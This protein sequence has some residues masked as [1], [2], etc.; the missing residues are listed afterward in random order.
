V[1]TRWTAESQ[2]LHEM[3]KERFQESKSRV[4]DILAEMIGVDPTTLFSE[5]EK[6]G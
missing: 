3:G 1:L 4:L 2:S 5:A 6:D